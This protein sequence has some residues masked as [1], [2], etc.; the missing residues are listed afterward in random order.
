MH[1]LVDRLGA[2]NY[3][4][5][6]GLI[7]NGTGIS[8]HITFWNHSDIWSIVHYKYKEKFCVNRDHLNKKIKKQGW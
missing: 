8:V 2:V 7:I 5:V 6:D 1:I 4:C 3:V